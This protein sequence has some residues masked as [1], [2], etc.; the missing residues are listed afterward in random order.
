MTELGVNVLW[1]DSRDDGDDVTRKKARRLINYLIGLNVNTVALN[2]LFVMGDV[3]ASEVKPHE[4]QTPSL[5]RIAIFLQEAEASAL[6]VRLRPLL[7]EGSLGTAWRGMIDPTSR[8]KWFAS[9]TKFLLPYARVAE[10][11][12]AVGMVLAAELN[13]LQTDRR[14]NDVIDKIREVFGGELTYSANFD[15]YEHRIDTPPVDRVGV[16]AYF[17]VN[18][19]D[20]ATVAELSAEWG[21]WLKKY[22]GRQPGELVL[23][24]VGIAAQNGAFQNPAIWGSSRVRLNLSVQAKWYA[25]ICDAVAETKLGGLYFWNIRMHHNPGHEDPAQADRLTFVDRP[26]EDVLRDCYAHLGA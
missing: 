22:A 25:A 10:E 6:R 15:A 7:D 24:E 26:A 11:H 1:E 21:K 19:P 18:L 23:H 8:A 2:F 16:D 12:G 3:T 20:N 4:G 5:E 14:W 13:S 17:K 9:Y